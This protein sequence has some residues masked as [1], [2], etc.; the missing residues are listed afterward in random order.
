MP[1]E[2]G[3]TICTPIIHFATCLLS[4]RDINE[5]EN[6][7]INEKIANALRSKPPSAEI[8]LVTPRRFKR[9]P[10]EIITRRLRKTMIKIVFKNRIC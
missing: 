3:V 7:K 9:N 2:A 4:K 1:G 5:P 10:T 8:K 6:P